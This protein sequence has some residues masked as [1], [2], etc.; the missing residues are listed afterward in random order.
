MGVFV[1]P[2]FRSASAF[3]K[4]LALGFILFLCASA[5]CQKKETEKGECPVLRN[6]FDRLEKRAKAGNP[7]AQTVLASCYELGRNVKPNGLETIR[8]LKLAAEQGYAPAE[9]ELG[10]MYLY[11]RGIPADYQQALLWETKASLQGERSAQRDLAFMYERGLGVPPD[12]RE[13][14]LWNRKAAEQGE[15]QAQV[16]LAEALETGSGVPENPAEARVRYLK[17]ARQGVARAQLRVAQIY[18]ADAAATCR[19]ALVWY[20]QAAAGGETQAMYESG[21]LY[22]TTKCG[23][24]LLSAFVWFR[25]GGRF[26]SKESQSEAEKVASSLSPAQKKSAELRVERWIKGHSGAQKEEDEKEK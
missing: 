6:E 10:R 9:Y 11:G 8:W 4:V 12:P 22:Q 13:A 26:G 25:I 14:A 23:P 24:D 1:R 3:L 17:A 5:Y 18:A 19:T 2:H 20:R 16:H 7:Q 21:K 15:P